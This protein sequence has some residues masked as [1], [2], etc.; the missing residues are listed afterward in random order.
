MR[1]GIYAPNWIGDAVLSLPFLNRCRRSFPEAHITVIA[2]TRVAAIFMHHPAA[3][4]LL[5]LRVLS[6]KVFSPPHAAA[7]A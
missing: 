4:K 2:K 7:E 6:S 5:P 3:L 1:I